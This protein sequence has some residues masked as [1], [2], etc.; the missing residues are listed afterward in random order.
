MDSWHGELVK[1]FNWNP[2]SFFT[3]PRSLASIDMEGQFEVGE[4]LLESAE[5]PLDFDIHSHFF[6][7]M[8]S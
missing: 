8:A 7:D 2:L 3:F 6:L 1:V 4:G 5:G